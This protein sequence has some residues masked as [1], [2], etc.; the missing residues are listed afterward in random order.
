LNF[1]GESIALALNRIQMASNLSEVISK[2][3]FWFKI[4][5]SPKGFAG[6][7]AAGHR[8]KPEVRRRRIEGFEAMHQQ[9]G[10]AKRHF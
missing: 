1:R 10:W 5:S 7:R 2:I 9:T 3:G 4:P 6:T 8:F